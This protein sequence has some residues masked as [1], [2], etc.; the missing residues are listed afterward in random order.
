MEWWEVVTGA[1]VE[2]LGIRRGELLAWAFKNH[3]V[4]QDPCDVYHTYLL[5]L[6]RMY[7]H[8][9]SEISDAEEAVRHHNLKTLDRREV[10]LVLSALADISG[11]PARYTGGHAKRP[12]STQADNYWQNQKR[13]A[14]FLVMSQD[15]SKVFVQASEYDRMTLN[16]KL[17][18]E[19]S[20]TG[21]GRKRRLQ[22]LW[23]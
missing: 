18:P 21:P 19:G 14:F 15:N 20:R 5:G 3:G 6:S 1:P 4:E 17:S 11:A 16:S 23:A 8:Y 9:R 2:N 12:R 10:P 7:Y 22:L 13:Q